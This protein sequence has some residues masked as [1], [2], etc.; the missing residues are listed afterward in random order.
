MFYLFKA[1]PALF[2]TA[3]FMESLAT[4]TL[5]IYVIRTKETPF[6]ESSPSKYLLFSTLGMVLIGWIL[7]YTIVGRYFGFEPLSIKIVLV[8]FG[9]VLSYLMLVEIMK[10]YFYRKNDF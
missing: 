3:W 1:P 7:P 2:Q 10:R 8:L 9:L 6:L 5:V 4:Q